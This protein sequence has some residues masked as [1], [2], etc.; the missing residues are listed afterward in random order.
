MRWGDARLSVVNHH[1][2]GHEVNDLSLLRKEQFCPYL[3]L[4]KGDTQAWVV[5]EDM[6]LEK[7]RRQRSDR[8][9]ASAWRI[10]CRD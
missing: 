3:H 1:A 2:S 7:V 9:P 5:M 10:S 6:R 4:L 8:L